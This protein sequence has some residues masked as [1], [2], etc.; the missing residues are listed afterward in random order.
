MPLLLKNVTT[1]DNERKDVHLADVKENWTIDLSDHV[2]Y[3]GLTNWHDHLE[4]NLYPKLGTPPYNNY[5]EWMK[6]I[7]KPKESPLK[8]IE[9]TDIDYRLLWGA[10]KN[11]VSGV[12][13]VYHHNPVRRI[14][15]KEPFPVFVPEIGWAHSLAVEKAFRYEKHLPFIIHAAEGVDDFARNEIHRLDDMGVLQKNTFIVH[16]IAADAK[17]VNSRN[18]TLIW[19]PS[20]NFYMF[21]KTADVKLFNKVV[22]GT[23]STLTGSPTLL[24]EMRVAAQFMS[25]REVFEMVKGEGFFIAR[26]LEADPVENLF[27]LH[28]K[29]IVMVISRGKIRLESGK[30]VGIDINKL[31]RH[32]EKKVGLGILEKNPLWHLI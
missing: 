25:K 20:S 19:C 17:L 8:E 15:R 26:K 22:L 13:T 30:P 12:T 9:K 18:A 11:L 27:R 1:V 28:P 2:L 16:G 29:D 7:Y 31:R 32:F 21:N 10:L 6:D 4:M 5:T 14:L 23:D 24:D 3:P